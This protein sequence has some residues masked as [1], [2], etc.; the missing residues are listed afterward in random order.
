MTGDKAMTIEGEMGAAAYLA[1]GQEFEWPDAPLAG[2]GT[3]DL[4]Q[5]RPDGPASSFV[6][7]RMIPA[8]K[9]AWWTAWSPAYKFAISYIWNRQEFPWLGIWEENCARDFSPWNSKAVT[10]G[11]E[12]GTTPFAESRQKMT[13]RVRLFDTPAYKWLPALGTLQASYAIRTAVAE[14]IPDTVSMPA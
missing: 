2:G 4:T 7:L 9:H 13:E 6:A 8:A 10:R 3:L 5:M 11:M 12:F 1:L 14:S